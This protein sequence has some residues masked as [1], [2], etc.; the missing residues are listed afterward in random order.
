MAP[1]PSGPYIHHAAA[2]S[3]GCSL[4]GGCK[5]ETCPFVSQA[6]NFQGLLSQEKQVIAKVVVRD[7]TCL[8]ID[9][10]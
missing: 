8:D 7:K 2:S 5:K 10:F 6:D 4:V 3:G 1:P 9:L